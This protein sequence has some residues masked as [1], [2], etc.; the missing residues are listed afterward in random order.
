MNW[1]II[2]LGNIAHEFAE[3]MEAAGSVYGVSSRNY[4]KALDFQNQYNI[5]KVYKS[6]EELLND[7]DIDIVYIATVNSQ[8]YQN[9]MD[10]LKS[11]KHVLCEKAIWD[12][13]EE[14]KKAYLYAQEHGL[15]LAEAMTIYHMP[16]FTEIKNFIEQ[17]NLG[18]LKYVNANLGSLKEDN[19]LNRFFSKELGGGAML[20]IGTYVLSFLRFFLQDEII[21]I[22]HVM[23]KYK[24]GVDEMWSI[25]VKTD[26]DI[27]GNANITF[28]SKLPK[29]AIIAGEKAYITI[30][31]YVRADKAVVTYPDGKEETIE[32]GNTNNALMYEILDIEETIKNRKVGKDYIN[33]TM[34][35]VYLM[36]KLLTIEGL[37]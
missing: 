7:R 19:P 30:D 4:Q 25:A 13:Y 37:K 32:C 24:T 26:Q 21:E 8:H 16:L 22:K 17:G 11:G 1:G 28:R 14:L 20:D 2:G 18:K 3:S 33:Q 10:C 31:N 9:I 29:K 36:D 6:Y 35:V 27:I 23:S 12:D 34:D 15:I 5:K